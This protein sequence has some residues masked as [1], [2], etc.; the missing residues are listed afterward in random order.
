MKVMILVVTMFC[1]QMAICEPM[2]WTVQTQELGMMGQGGGPRAM[3][4]RIR[5]KVKA[6]KAAK[7]DKAAQAQAAQAQAPRQ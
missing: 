6:R 3:V 2:V 7:A 5:A 4:A 1:S